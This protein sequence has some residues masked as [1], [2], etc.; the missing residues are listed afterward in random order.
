MEG[1]PHELNALC[2]QVIL[3]CDQFES[4]QRLRSFCRGHEALY[5][6]NF[7][8]KQGSDC[9]SLFELNLP[10]FIENKH[11]KYGWIFPIFVKALATACPEGDDRRKSLDDLHAK[12]KALQHQPQKCQSPIYSYDERRLFNS[13][14][15][16]DFDEQ[17]EEVTNALRLQK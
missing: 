10:S 6:V 16:I 3:K 5:F 17:Q 7:K 1:L 8:L 14:L 15:E 12:I 9:E 4:Y 11:E 13:I 2:R